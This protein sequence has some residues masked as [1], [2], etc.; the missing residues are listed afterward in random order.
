LK[1]TERIGGR[2]LA[3]GTAVSLAVYLAMLALAALLV[4]RGR[5]GEGYAA[6]CTYVC[7]FLAAFAGAK[8]ASWG[9]QNAIVP[10]AACVGAAFCAILLLGYLTNDVLDAHRVLCLAVSMAAGCLCALVIRIR[11]KGRKHGRRVRR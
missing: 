2:R 7:A 11:K 4:E 1:Q 9:T 5:V 10:S 8:A 3:L 6:T